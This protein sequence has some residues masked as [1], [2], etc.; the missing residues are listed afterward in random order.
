MGV[1]TDAIVFYG[2]CWDEEMDLLPEEAEDEWEEVVLKKRGVKSPWDDYLSD[3]ELDGLPWNERQKANDQWYEANHA[4]LND[5]RDAKAAVAREFACV[6]GH[7]CVSDDSMPYVC[8]A[9]SVQRAGSG[10]P[11]EL[12]LPLTPVCPDWDEKLE[13]FLAELGIVRP[14]ERPRWW[15]VNYQG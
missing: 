11:K 13:K 1:S 3:E 2:Y 4:A 8:V 10:S 15:L 7:H 14:Q 9:D 5:W 6:V 12:N